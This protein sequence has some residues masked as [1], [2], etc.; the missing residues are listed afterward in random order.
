MSNKSVYAITTSQQQTEAI[1]SRLKAEG[2]ANDR[3]SVLFPDKSTT[4][5]FAHEKHTKS[6]EGAVTGG[7]SG[8]LLGGALGW[9]AG[10]GALAIP[11]AG[12]FIAAGPL[13][14]A[15]GGAFA[16]ATLGGIAGALVGMGLPEIEAKR[17]E[18]KVKDGNILIS[19]H[20]KD[21]DE[22]SLAKGILK[23][24]DA[25]DIC[26]ASMP[27]SDNENRDDEKDD[28]EYNDEI[29]LNSHRENHEHRDSRNLDTVA[30]S[31]QTG[32]SPIQPVGMSGAEEFHGARRDV[33]VEK[34]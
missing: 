7:V 13:A 18:D 23:E 27:K 14:A 9:I 8:G 17:Y 2:F 20:A 26:T 28:E 16:G 12:P 33:V 11:G 30:L 15:I 21:S 32:V 34:K 1:V 4:S 25:G 5:D 31:S 22:V 29:I 10:I 3:I 19:V 24:H 6:P